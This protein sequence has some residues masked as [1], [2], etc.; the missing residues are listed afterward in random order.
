M[1]TI[2][3]ATWKR[4]DHYNLYRNLDFPYLNITTNV[5]ITNLYSWSKE[6]QVSLFSCIAYFT[7]HAANN[8]PALRLRIR[9]DQVV[10]HPVVHPSF[11]VLTDDETF[12]FATI[13][14]SPEFAGFHQNVITGIEATKQNPSIHDEP[15]RDDL[16]FLTT[17]TWVSF[18]QIS[19]P[20]PIHPPDSFPRI[21]W[22]KYF[23]Q[24]DQRLMPLSLFA[25]HALVDGI[26]VGQFFEIVQT[27]MNQPEQLLSNYFI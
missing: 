5:D 7:T 12:G 9:G 8:I 19:H 22:G 25:N 18:T 26:H 15:G 27:W 14:Y 20:V 6:H 23:V 11:T 13:Q 24:G 21:T 10:E 17:M 4:K 1:K 16:I 2:D 3:L